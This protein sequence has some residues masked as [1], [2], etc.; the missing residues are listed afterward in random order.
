MYLLSVDRGRAARLVNEQV[1]AAEAAKQ[2]RKQDAW[3]AVHTN[4]TPSCT[5]PRSPDAHSPQP[6]LPQHLPPV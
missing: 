3:R 1:G 6:F 2:A 4:P 5:R